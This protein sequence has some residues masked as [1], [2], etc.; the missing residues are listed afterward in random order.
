MSCKALT[1]VTA[2]PSSSGRCQCSGQEYHRDAVMFGANSLRPARWGK[3]LLLVI[4]VGVGFVTG[5]RQANQPLHTYLKYFKITSIR[6]TKWD[7]KEKLVYFYVWPRILH[8]RI[9]MWIPIRNRRAVFGEEHSV[10]AELIKLNFLAL[11]VARE[12]AYIYT[13]R[14]NVVLIHAHLR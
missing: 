11:K 13:R 14:S 1:G 8:V 3:A 10:W 2:D 9:S 5:S 7:E 4:L 6:I 12:H